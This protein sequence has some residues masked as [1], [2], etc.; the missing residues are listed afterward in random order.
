MLRGALIEGKVSPCDAPCSS[1]SEGKVA[2][3]TLRQD[4]RGRTMRPPLIFVLAGAFVTFAA[5]PCAKATYHFDWLEQG[6]QEVTVGGEPC[7]HEESRLKCKTGAYTCD[8]Q[9]D[10]SGAN[11]ACTPQDPEHA[12]VGGASGSVYLCHDLGTEAQIDCDYVGGQQEC[13]GVTTTCVCKFHLLWGWDCTSVVVPPYTY[14]AQN[15]DVTT[16]CEM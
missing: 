16:D 11:L 10:S 8:A 15:I 14:S 5:Y 2:D 12:Q 1:W 4:E 13:T 7:D 3:A 9:C 6:V